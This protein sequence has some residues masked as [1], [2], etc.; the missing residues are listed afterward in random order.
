MILSS[1]S[2]FSRNSKKVAFH[3]V[4]V[5]VVAVTDSSSVAVAGY[6]M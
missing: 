4:V 2:T 5:V 1:V 3:F 6:R